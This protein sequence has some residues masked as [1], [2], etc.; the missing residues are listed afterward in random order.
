TL[1]ESDAL[2]LIGVEQCVGCAASEHGFEFPRQIDGVADPG[3]HALPAGGTMNVCRIAEQKRAPFPEML[4]YTMMNMI[5]RKPVYFFDI[6]LEVL[7]DPAADI[8]EFERI[9][10]IGAVVTHRPDQSRASLPGERKH[11][12]EI[13]FFE[14]DVQ[15]TIDCRAGRLDI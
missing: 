6:D 2:A 1:G 5:S 4:R 7:D 11:G 12:K 14:V 13:S 8:L 3:I 10:A 9:G 15:L